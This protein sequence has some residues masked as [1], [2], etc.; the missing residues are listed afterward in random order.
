MG[1]DKILAI[2]VF[3]VG[4]MAIFRYWTL[5][6]EHSEA[7]TGFEL[8]LALSLAVTALFGISLKF[9]VKEE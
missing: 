4:A 7:K 9:I 2:L 6:H 8:L 1:R 3:I 5:I